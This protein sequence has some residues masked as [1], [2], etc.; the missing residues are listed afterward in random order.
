MR[1]IMMTQKTADREIA[2]G[3]RIEA[4]LDRII[5]QKKKEAVR[6]LYRNTWIEIQK[7]LKVFAL[8]AEWTSC[9]EFIMNGGKT[10]PQKIHKITL[11]SKFVTKYR[12]DGRFI[13]HR[14]YEQAEGKTP[15][16]ALIKLRKGLENDTRTDR[17]RH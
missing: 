13:S 11:I 1:E 8:E 3:K 9:T 4:K 6:C 10:P 12:K 2:E 7:A 14:L 16:A 5:K 15:Q 17:K